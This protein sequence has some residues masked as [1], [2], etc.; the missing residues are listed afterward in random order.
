MGRVRI[1]VDPETNFAKIRK[2]S[3]MKKT[4][5]SF[6]GISCGTGRDAYI[7][8]TAKPWTPKKGTVVRKEFRK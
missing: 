7:E 6:R 4:N 2:G 3:T 1:R 5:H 8:A